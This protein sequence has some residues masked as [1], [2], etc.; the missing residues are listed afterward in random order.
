MM[1]GSGR[2]Y[3]SFCMTM[4]F[5]LWEDFLWIWVSSLLSWPRRPAV[6]VV[7]GLFPLPPSLLFLPHLAELRLEGNFLHRLPSEVSTLQHLKTIDLSRNQF[8]D[9]PEQLTTLPA[10]ENINLE[11]NEIVG[12][13]TQPM[14]LPLLCLQSLP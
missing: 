9:F 4:E 3:P 2:G 10:L 13:W 8:H 12:E 6:T 7:S 5:A 14:A 11:E 1:G